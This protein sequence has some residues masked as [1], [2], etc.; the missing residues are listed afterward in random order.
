MMQLK[1]HEVDYTLIYDSYFFSFIPLG[2]EVKLQ[3]DIYR[4][5]QEAECAQLSTGLLH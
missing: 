4:F 3:E 2:R 5:S 1:H